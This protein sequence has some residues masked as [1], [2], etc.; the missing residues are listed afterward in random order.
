MAEEVG[1]EALESSTTLTVVL[2]L[3]SFLSVETLVEDEA[4]EAETADGNPLKSSLSESLERV[5][6][7]DETESKIKIK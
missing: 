6:R 4:R 7:G 1:L 5:E 3:G 2:G